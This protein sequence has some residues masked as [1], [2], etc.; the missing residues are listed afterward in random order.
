MSTPN[1]TEDQLDSRRASF[2]EAVNAGINAKRN[3]NAKWNSLY[4]WFESELG[5]GDGSRGITVGK[6]ITEGRQIGNRCVE[7][8]SDDLRYAIISHP[9]EL[10]SARILK[11]MERH[12]K[13]PSLRAVLFLVDD[14]PERLVIIDD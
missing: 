11:A 5:V 4:E 8:A 14:E 7:M 13:Y 10:D 2:L 3:S 12:G 6:V 1:D 9:P